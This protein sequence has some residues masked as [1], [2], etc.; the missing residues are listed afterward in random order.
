MVLDVRASVISS[1]GPVISGSLTDDHIQGQGLITTSGEIVIAGLVT[2]STGSTVSLG[3]ITA[4]GGRAARFPRGPFRVVQSFA[5]PLTRQTTVK[6][7]DSLAYQK[8]QGGG[9]LNSNVTEAI[10]DRDPTINPSVNLRDTAKL[11]CERLGV[12]VG[13]LG[14]W[15]LR[16][17]LPGIETDDYVETLSDILASSGHVAYLDPENKLQA[18]KYSSLGDAG[19]VLTFEEIIDLSDTAGGLNYSENPSATGE[20]QVVDEVDPEEDESEE[21]SLDVTSVTPDG[22]PSGGGDADGGDYDDDDDDDDAHVVIDETSAGYYFQDTLI[23]STTRTENSI[24]VSKSDGTL[25][26]FSTVEEVESTDQVMEPDNRVISRTQ[27]T[28]NHL[29]KLNSQVVQDHLDAGIGFDRASEVHEAVAN[30]TFTYVQSQPRGRNSWTKEQKERY[31]Q[32]IEAAAAN[33]AASSTRALEKLEV[34]LLP[35]LPV[36]RLVRQEATRTLPYVE[37]LG[38]VG[39]QDY[40]V[41]PSVP[42]S[43]SEIESRVITEYRYLRDKLKTTTRKYVAYGLTQMGQQSIAAFAAKVTTLSDFNNILNHFFKLVLDDVSINISPIGQPKPHLEMYTQSNVRAADIVMQG[44]SQVQV[45]GSTSGLANN[46]EAFDMAYVPDD[47]LTDDGTIFTAGGD[48]TWDESSWDGSSDSGSPDEVVYASDETQEEALTRYAEEQNQQLLGHRQGMQIVTGLD[49]FPNKPLAA[50]HVQGNGQTATYRVNGTSWSFDQNSCLVSTDALYWGMAG[51]SVSGSLWAPIAPG[52]TSLP[53]APST[54]TNSSNNSPTNPVN[55]VTLSTPLDVSNQ[56]AVN[57]VLAS[58]PNNQTQTHIASLAPTQISRPFKVT[59][60]IPAVI[61]LSGNII[62]RPAGFTLPQRDIDSQVSI[63]GGVVANG[64][65]TDPIT[66]VVQLKTT[67]SAGVI[68]TAPVFES[69]LTLG[70]TLS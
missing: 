69:G 54:T 39:L 15:T 10:N 6:L 8:G 60:D 38:R 24:Y 27:V 25:V 46:N 49:K 41:L 13:S 68:A 64:I 19:P 30:E 44:N 36:F 3:Y 26:E 59:V 57:T 29:V 63:Q 16:K 42:S 34:L 35:E 47:I 12:S 62:V 56:T 14:S 4:D 7:A 51:G 28:R 53:T 1:I 37:A 33:L 40:S 32:E 2:P 52:V 23:K 5:N 43:G 17:Q 67:I 61:R 58:L 11:I 45:S 31:D 20:A 48:Y 55:S 9:L 18:V 21:G 50:F 65:L 70:G 22:F 66:G